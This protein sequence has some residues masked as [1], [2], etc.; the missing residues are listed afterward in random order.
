MKTLQELT[1]QEKTK[2]ILKL[3]NNQPIIEEPKQK[4]IITYSKR[5]LLNIIT[6]N[7][8][9]PPISSTLA[10]IPIENQKVE[11]HLKTISD[12][13]PMITTLYKCK[14]GHIALILLPISFN[15]LYSNTNQLNFMIMKGLE[16]ASFIKSQVIS[17]AGLL[18]SATQ[19]GKTIAKK[20]AEMNM[21][22]TTGHATTAA[23]ILLTL[24]K[25][26]IEKNKSIQNLNVTVLG[27]GSIGQ[28]FCHLLLEKHF[29]P[30]K[31]TLCDV[32]SCEKM[33]NLIKK[34]LESKSS[35]AIDIS[36]SENDS[37]SKEV[38]ESDIIIGAT[39]KANIINIKQL[40]DDCI[41]LDDS[42]PHCFDVKEAMTKM[43]TSS[44]LCSEA[45]MLQMPYP[46]KEY[47]F[48]PPELKSI[49]QQLPGLIWKRKETEITSCILS[50]YLNA[51]ENIS[52]TLGIPRSN[53]SIEHYHLLK[54][55][56]IK[57]APFRLEGIPIP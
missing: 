40:K 57:A 33:L 20:C 1:H 19:Y 8:V 5:D 44:L 35:A 12:N 18:P 49:E 34:E 10:Y 54:K 21:L 7:T 30:Q 51:S 32:K 53:V 52:S 15:D 16:M 31:L 36:V 28:S 55:L 2:L 39:N 45:G 3:R 48:V 47:R 13:M 25:A 4:S 38:Y 6:C 29:T 9:P 22:L 26:L 14:K 50:G 24:E 46:I 56:D 41:I 23:S 17:L 11:Q 42:I 43:K 27:M 37:L